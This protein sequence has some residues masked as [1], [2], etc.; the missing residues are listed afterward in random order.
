VIAFSTS[1]PQLCATTG[2]PSANFSGPAELGT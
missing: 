1:K 2:L